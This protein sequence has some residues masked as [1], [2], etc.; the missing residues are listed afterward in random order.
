MGPWRLTH[1][2]GRGGMGV[3]WEASGP[4]GVVAL[5]ML[6]PHLSS[7]KGV[8]ARFLREAEVGRLIEHKNVVRT[9]DAGQSVLAGTTV[10]WLAMER[11][12]GRTLAQEL[13][14]NGP[15]NETICWELARQMADALAEIHRHRVV[16]RDVKP[17]NVLVDEGGR[18]L[19]MDLGVARVMDEALKL[20]QTGMFIGSVRY[21]APE[22]FSGNHDLDGRADQYALGAT[23]YHVATGKC[24]FAGRTLPELFAQKMQGAPPAMHTVAPH[25]SKRLEVLVARMLARDATRRLPN[26]GAVQDAIAR[27]ESMPLSLDTT[28][29]EASIGV[30]GLPLYSDAF[31]GRAPELEALRDALSTARLLTLVGPGG[32]GK[33]R[34]ATTFAK[35]FAD[36]WGGGVWFAS[37]TEARSEIGICRAVART[38]E[39]QLGADPVVHVGRA[40]RGRGRAL[41]ILDNFEQVV[42]FARATVAQWLESAPNAVFLVTSREALAIGG[43]QMMHVEPLPL[44]TDSTPHGDAVALFEAR[45]RQAQPAFRVDEDNADD[46]A[47]LVRALDGLPLAIELAASR[48]R[49]MPPV[50]LVSRL[51]DR[52]KFLRSTRRDLEARQATLRGTLDWSWDLLEPWARAAFVQCGIFDGGFTLDAAE[53]VLDLS[54]FADAPWPMDAVQALVD[55]SLLRVLEGARFGMFQS[56]HAY[57]AERLEALDDADLEGRHGRYY[58]Q[59]GGASWMA[60]LSLAGGVERYRV[61]SEEL[62]NLVVACRRAIGRQDA[63][64]A[65]DTAIAASA[66]LSADGPITAAIDLGEAALAIVEDTEDRVRLLNRHGQA[67]RTQGRFPDALVLFDEAVRLARPG[68]LLAANAQGH[69]GTTRSF[70]G[71]L[72][73]AESDLNSAIDR[74]EALG[75]KGRRAV[76]LDGLS[77]VAGHRGQNDLRYALS[78]EA[79]AVYRAIG[80]V[81]GQAVNLCNLGNDLTTDNRDG[82][83]LE[84]LEEAVQTAGT[85]RLLTLVGQATANI[86][87]IHLRRGRLLVAND[88]LTEGLH[89]ARRIGNRTVEGYALVG[90]GEVSWEAGATANA[91]RDLQRAAD[92]GVD[93]GVRILTTHALL[94][95]ARIARSQERFE[96]ERSHLEGAWSHATTFDDGTMRAVIRAERAHGLRR[97]QELDAA[98]RELEAALQESSGQDSPHLRAVLEGEYA[99]HFLQ[100]GDP[101][102]AI[103]HATDAV[104]GLDELGAELAAARAR[105]VLARALHPYDPTGAYAV[106]MEASGWAKG[107]ELPLDSRLWLEIV[108]G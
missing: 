102:R 5:K 82:E 4:S 33:T 91:E 35:R 17:G 43:E 11:V 98:K 10:S 89:H 40:I 88:Y 28:V 57:A 39:V 21:A 97:K 55:K 42:P 84:A 99:I 68:T 45:A 79:L 51:D 75:E 30:Q 73:E 52:F 29:M 105:T 92:L 1:Q 80:D 14:A 48:I 12:T 85:V 50:V 90:R 41:V 61:M 31:I 71:Q 107:V 87:V 59:Y 64:V 106:S 69:R 72:D 63:A 25:L 47:T 7:A 22:Q 60:S 108:G 32:T 49:L 23:L 101:A 103:G 20:S 37:L 24:P 18:F 36:D 8:M 83:A 86:G 70:L 53:E 38:M 16:H 6:H 34:L 19:L 96:T 26:M 46:V 81:R 15:L 44:P 56:I 95:L 100:C 78:R 2:L 93:C 9:L 58:A 94:W 76:Y 27:R 74:L 13:D 65:T 66:V 104:A 77:N 62:D 3:V 67:V 54:G